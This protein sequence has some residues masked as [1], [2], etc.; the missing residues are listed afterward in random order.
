MTPNTPAGARLAAALRELKE[1]TDLSLAGLAERTAYSK[2]SWDRY[3]HGKALPPRQAVQALCGLARV[4]DERCLALW[5][6]A[7]SEW[8]GRATKTKETPAETP[9]A[10]EPSPPAA[11]PEP[12]STDNSDRHNSDRHKSSTTM[13]AIAL[14]CVVITAGVAVALLLP[15]GDAR[16]RALPSPSALTALCQGAACAGQ[17]PMHM[18]CAG[19]PATL[20]TYHA[21]GGAWVELR[22]SKECGTSWARMWGTRVG[23]RVEVIAAGRM[24][25]ARITDQIDA[26]AYVHT[27]MLP[28]APG[29]VVRACFHPAAGG[30]E[31][32][33]E[34]PV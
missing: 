2:S 21:T 23:D 15:G 25:D 34:A 30:A 20:T 12:P 6:I 11:P 32:C 10:G 8:R 17:N 31:E 24:Q 33:F 7:E 13:A 14:A 5:E 19:K 16:P 9:E 26:E 28:A 22:F 3:L 1:R 4:S 18:H 27:A 29:T